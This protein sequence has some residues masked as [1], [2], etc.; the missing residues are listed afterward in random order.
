[1]PRAHLGEQ[2]GSEGKGRDAK[3][4]DKSTLGVDVLWTWQAAMRHFKGLVSK[5]GFR[6]HCL[7]S[8]KAFMHYRYNQISIAGKARLET[9]SRTFK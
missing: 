6:L 5:T 1:L 9:Y 7:D 2:A 3:K 4:E 8:S